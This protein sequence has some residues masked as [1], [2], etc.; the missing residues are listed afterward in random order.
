MKL[1]SPFLLILLLTIQSSFAVNTDTGIMDEH[2]QY[3]M[4][5]LETHPLILI[6]KQ[7]A[8]HLGNMQ[9]NLA[10]PS[11]IKGLADMSEEVKMQSA[12]SLGRLGD[13]AALRPLYELI[14]S[15]GTAQVQS[16]ARN[17]IDKINSHE[18]FKHQQKQKLKE[19][20]LKESN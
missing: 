11:L 20:E 7:A 4:K 1:K 9:N 2:I 14:E 16:A 12:Y 13:P 6:R 10:I 17:A 19:L 15:G 3:W 5:V 8:R 18:E